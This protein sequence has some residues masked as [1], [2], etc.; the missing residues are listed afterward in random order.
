MKSGTD[1]STDRW[2]TRNSLIDRAKNQNDEQSWE[3][4]VSYYR[5][6]I[7]IVLNKMGL[8]SQSEDLLQEILIRI[9]KGLGKFEYD[10]NR[11]RFRSWL[12]KIVR[13]TTYTYLT[14]NK[15]HQGNTSL[16]DEDNH[17]LKSIEC[18]K[19]NHELEE[20][21]ES[22]WQ[23]YITDMAIGNLKPLFSERA[24]VVFNLH[25]KG[26]S[27]TEISEEIG[28]KENS[29][30]KL[31]NRFKTRLMEEVVRLLEELDP[32]YVHSA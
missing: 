22:E 15:K 23:V 27:I 11:A 4:F 20:V 10:K 32:S 14:K 13:N 7:I 5:E 30:Y 1:K 12:V 25:L 29:V 17:F 31:K 8:R 2:V 24:Y 9:W 3:E 21:I 28:I 6:F 19:T 18:Q 26:K 16:D